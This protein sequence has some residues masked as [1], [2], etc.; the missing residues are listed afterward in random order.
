M[1]H[2]L[3]EC[4]PETACLAVLPSGRSVSEGNQLQMFC[5]AL[6]NDKQI[7]NKCTSQTACRVFILAACWRSVRACRFLRECWQHEKQ[8]T[9]GVMLELM[10]NLKCAVSRSPLYAERTND[11]VSDEIRWYLLILRGG[12]DAEKRQKDFEAMRYAFWHP[13]CKHLLQLYRRLK[14]SEAN[15]FLDEAL[16]PGRK[17]MVEG[18]GQNRATCVI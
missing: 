4:R 2:R 12:R 13:L 18:F 10:S 8:T 14:G 9:V 1:V 11:E 15:R 5:A 7:R 16:A 17:E 3:F 6:N